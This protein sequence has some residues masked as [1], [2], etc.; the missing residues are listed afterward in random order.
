M[1]LT[2]KEKSL[3]DKL[4]LKCLSCF[5]MEPN[6]ESNHDILQK[7]GTIS[8]VAIR[9]WTIINFTKNI[10]VNC[11]NCFLIKQIREG[12]INSILVLTNPST[13]LLKKIK[14]IK[15]IHKMMAMLHHSKDNRKKKE[16]IHHPN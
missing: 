7:F 4:V 1:A 10:I 12:V 6:K 14:K 16:E 9:I 5:S 3:M 15:K 13:N 8:S 2:K 11:W